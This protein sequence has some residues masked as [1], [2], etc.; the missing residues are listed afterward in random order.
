MALVEVELTSSCA[1]M[2]GGERDTVK[3]NSWQ[4]HCGRVAM[5]LRKIFLSV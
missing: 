2:G 1:G 3:G 5:S 4:S